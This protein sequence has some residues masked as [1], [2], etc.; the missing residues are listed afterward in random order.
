LNTTDTGDWNIAS[1]ARTRAFRTPRSFD[2]AATIYSHGWC[3]LAP[4]RPDE[5]EK[6]LER[7]WRVEGGPA[8]I[9]LLQPSGPGGEVEMEVVAGR[10]ARAGLTAAT[11]SGV[12]RD[13]RHMLRLDEDFADFHARCRLAG[14][15]FDRAAAGG[16]GRLLRSPTLFEDVVKV[17][18]TTNTT[19][20]GTIAMVGK[21]VELA[22]HDAF[23]E[24]REVAALGSRK[25]QDAARWGYRAPYL[26]GLAEA[27]ASGRLDLEAWERWDGSTADLEQEIR[28]VP[29]LGPY[30]AA[31][32]LTLLGRYDRIGVDT[33]FRSFVKR[34]HFPRARKPV[35]DRRMLAVY[36]R[37]GEW[38]MLAYW[39]EVWTDYV[40]GA[41]AKEG[42]PSEEER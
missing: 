6:T 36:D 1:K 14:P 24:P 31:Q 30:A 5:E 4:N 33:V 23:P 11:W 42:S 3:M 25:I 28:R 16:F 15:P 29:G 41:A 35:S 13:V 22:G 7:A 20:S 17:L 34:T 18:A 40:D 26:V 10:G 37:W 39:F 32:V 2:L 21:L 12:E 38:K 9:R 27:V 19:W 8:R